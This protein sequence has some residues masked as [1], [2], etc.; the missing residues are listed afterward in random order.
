MCI[1]DRY[2]IL[3]TQSS[4]SYTSGTYG[5]YLF[6]PYSQGI[7]VPEEVSTNETATGDITYDVFLSKMCI[8]DRVSGRHLP[9]TDRG[10]ST[11][12]VGETQTILKKKKAGNHSCC[13]ADRSF[14][15]GST[16]RRREKRNCNYKGGGMICQP[17]IREN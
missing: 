10:C 7:I 11:Y 8:R 1:R 16:A 14:G 5:K 4:D 12:T 6:L 2:Y 17:F 15:R 3:P 13:T 9:G